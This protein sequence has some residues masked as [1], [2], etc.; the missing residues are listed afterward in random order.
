M[1]GLAATTSSYSHTIQ[2]AV[3]IFST[4]STLQQHIKHTYH[5]K[6]IKRPRLLD[7][8]QRLLQVRQLA[9]HHTLGLL[10]IL[11]RLRLEGLDGLDLPTH[12]VRHQ[13]EVAEVPLDLVHDSPVLQPLPVGR[14]VDRLRRL[15]ERL[16][17]AARV[18]VALLEGTECRCCLALQAKLCADFRPVDF[19]SGAALLEKGRLVS[20]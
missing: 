7:V 8:P 9:I 5:S 11:H 15:R 19:E 6:I 10:R 20:G 16:Q 4:R 2:L 18:V 12:I 14:E 13:L 17:L 3:Q 1:S